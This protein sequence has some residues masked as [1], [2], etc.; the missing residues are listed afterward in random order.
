MYNLSQIFK[1]E[2]LKNEIILPTIDK[3]VRTFQTLNGQLHPNYL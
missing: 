1:K 2:N 3:L